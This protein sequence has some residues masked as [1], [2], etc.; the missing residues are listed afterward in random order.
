ME[1]YVR[2]AVHVAGNKK[3]SAELRQKIQENSAK[4]FHSKEASLAWEKVFKDVYD[5]F[6]DDQDP[7][8]TNLKIPDLKNEFVDSC[9]ENVC[10]SKYTSGKSTAGTGRRRLACAMSHGRYTSCKSISSLILALLRRP[11]GFPWCGNRVLR[12]DRSLSG[13]GR[14]TLSYLRDNRGTHTSSAPG[15]T[16][17]SQS[18]LNEAQA[19]MM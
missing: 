11:R 5:K 18:Q 1:D 17:R 8:P 3:F 12:T 7:R 15:T 10:K 6:L 13:R 4:L 14:A 19:L 16:V 9:E 2:L